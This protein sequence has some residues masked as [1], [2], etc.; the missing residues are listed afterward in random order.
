[1]KKYDIG[2]TWIAYDAIG[3][4]TG[5]PVVFLHGATVDHVSMKNTFEPYFPGRNGGHRRI[6]PDFPGHGASGRQL[7]RASM[8]ALLEDVETFLRGNFSTPPALVGYSLGGFVALKLAE[9]IRFPSLFLIAPP[10]CTDKRRITRPAERTIISD[11]LTRAQEKTA[12]TRYLALAAKRTPQTLKRY[13]AGVPDGFSPGKFAY[14]TMLYRNAAAENIRIKPARIRSRTTFL[15]GQQ[16]TLTG[17]RDQFR[18]SSRLRNSEYHSF[19]DCGHF[20]PHE[21]GQFEALFRDWLRLEN[22]SRTA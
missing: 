8:T 6:Y 19:Y 1:M 9:K 14:Q 21:C 17:Y 18:L 13:K 12:D 7:T 20:L 3:P 16:D 10:V 2:R 5:R 11:E 15:V 22:S 4:G